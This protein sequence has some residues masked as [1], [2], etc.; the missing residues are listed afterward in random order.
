MRD[1][2]VESDEDG[3]DQVAGEAKH[4]AFVGRLSQRGGAGLPFMSAF[5]NR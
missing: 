3:W 2:I 5:P 1:R 4:T